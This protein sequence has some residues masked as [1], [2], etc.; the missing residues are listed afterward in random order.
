[1]AEAKANPKEKGKLRRSEAKMT[2][3]RNRSG[4]VWGKERRN[5]IRADPRSKQVDWTRWG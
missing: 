2:K 4:I 5:R 3:S 1:M